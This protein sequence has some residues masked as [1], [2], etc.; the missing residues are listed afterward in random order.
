MTSRAAIRWRDLVHAPLKR[1]VLITDATHFVI[2]EK[3][4]FEFF[5]AVYKFLNE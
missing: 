4:R 1:N 3:K 5:E 2:F